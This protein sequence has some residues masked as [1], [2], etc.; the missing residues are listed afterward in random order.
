MMAKRIIQ[1]CLGV[2]L[3]TTPNI[4]QAKFTLIQQIEHESKIDRGVVS[5]IAADTSL[6]LQF[7]RTGKW[8]VH[9]LYEGEFDLQATMN[10]IQEEQLGG[11]IVVQPLQKA[12]LLP[13]PDRFVNLLIIKQDI[14]NRYPFLSKESERVLAVRGARIV[15]G[16]PQARRTQFGF[17][18]H[19]DHHQQID[20]WSHRWYDATGNCVSYDKQVGFPVAIQWQHGPAMEDG[21]GDGKVPRIADGRLISL[22]A[23]TGE[24]VCRDAGNGLLLWKR[25]VGS[26]QNSDLAIVAERV[27]L[28]FDE[29]SL[30]TSNR[31][32]FAERG[33]LVAFDLKSGQL[34]QTYDEGLTGGTA[35]SIAFTRRSHGNRIFKQQPVPWFVVRED[36]IVQ[37]YGS[38]L[39]TLDRKTGKRIFSKSLSGDHTWFSP[40]LMKNR[41][42]V[43]EA[44][45]PARR[46]RHDGTEHV[47]AVVAFQLTDGKTLWRNDEVHPLREVEEKGETLL[48]RAEFKPISLSADYVLLHTSSYQFRQ[49][50]SIA[51][52]DIETGQERWRRAFPA[53]SLYTQ[54]SQRAVIR[55]KEVIVLDGTG[56]YRFHLSSGNPIGNPLGRKKFKRETRLNGAC[57]ASRATIDWLICNAY[58]YVGPKQEVKECFGARGQCGEG[59]IPANGLI[60][61]PPTACD[62]GD[63]TRGWQALTSKT[64]GIPHFEDRRLLKGPAYQ[65]FQHQVKVE[66]KEASTEDTNSPPS[67]TSRAILQAT[68]N[69]WPLF[70]GNAYRTSNSRVN[71]EIPQG[72]K[73]SRTVK[74]PFSVRGTHDSLQKDRQQS[75]RYLGEL[76]PPVIAAGV[77]VVSH[78]E[79]HNLRAFELSNGKLLWTFP[80]GGKVDSAPTL[81][82]DPSA[83]NDPSR[84][85]VLFGCDDGTVSAI[86]GSD[87]ALIW[88]FLASPT[89]GVVL[90]HGHFANPF[91]VPGSVLVLKD[92]VI[93]IAGHHT[94]LGGL[95]C[96]S[97]DLKSGVVQNSIHLKQTESAVISN[98]ILSADQEGSGFWIGSPKSQ[99]RF[100]SDLKSVPKMKKETHPLITF[101]RNGERIRFRTG[102][103]RGGSTHG[104]KGAMQSDWARAHRLAREGDMIY[105]LK[106]PTESDRHPVRAGKSILLSSG[107]GSWNEKQIRWETSV[108][109][110]GTKESYSAILKTNSHL[111]LGGGKRN[112]SSGFVQVVDPVGGKL[113]HEIKLG[114]V[115]EC[116]FAVVKGALFVSCED[117]RLYCLALE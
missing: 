90:S 34:L 114:R 107:S 11:R 116:G 7:A 69:Q 17:V 8:L 48:A 115:T 105:A 52:L 86:R 46:G 44:I 13:Y 95:Y 70:L 5:I 91:P 50:G 37:A 110:L 66:A 41:L 77:V 27:Y 15:R 76:S 92:R 80:T 81:V 112:G 100:T 29:K 75:E 21:T 33:P 79:Q 26:R 74:D 30:Q 68:E 97:L 60:F 43:A 24:L 12:G 42:I 93:V 36:V 96:Y 49:G 99:R 87:G 106:D 101:D 54:G 88:K 38:Q 104:W 111:F 84:M 85:I 6:A 22:D 65:E 47:G 61:V 9:L 109:S 55:G 98:G 62:C 51:L 1:S 19:S 16:S 25:Y 83:S 72:V 23:I 117:G 40:V 39:V 67:A 102:V 14:L 94:D 56:A 20:S 89:N 53:K 113:L 63:Y 32:A 28:W 10:R 3:L 45:Q 103:G 82:V 2:L 64:P 71:S 18:T 78:L 31:K 58:L 73:W 57:T 4:A 35:P 108:E 59:V